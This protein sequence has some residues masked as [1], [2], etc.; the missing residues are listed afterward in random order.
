MMPTLSP[1]PLVPTPL[2]GKPQ[3]SMSWKCSHGQK[4]GSLSAEMI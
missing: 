4:K 2:R 3:L 1:N